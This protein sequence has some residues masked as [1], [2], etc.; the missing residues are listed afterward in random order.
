MRYDNDMM[1]VEIRARDLTPGDLV[2]LGGGERRTVSSIL[3]LSDGVVFEVDGDSRGYF[4]ATDTPVTVQAVICADCGHP[5]T[6]CE[7]EG[8]DD[9]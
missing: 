7:C 8:R 4:M 1:P 6:D 2:N 9:A 5:P 3:V